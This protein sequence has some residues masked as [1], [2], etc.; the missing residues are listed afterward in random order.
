M[1]SSDKRILFIDDERTLVK[2]S[3][4]FLK[5]KGYEAIGT[6]L[7]E[8]ALRLFKC[9]PNSFDMVITDISM[10][11][12][13]GITLVKQMKEIND[14]IRVIFLSGVIETHYEKIENSIIIDKPVKPDYLI[15]LIENDIWVRDKSQKSKFLDYWNSKI[16]IVY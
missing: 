1:H 8:E 7:P 5:K 14:N 12:M 15:S 4:S 3:V 6:S 16:N 11:K 9:D 13:D 10:P 2:L